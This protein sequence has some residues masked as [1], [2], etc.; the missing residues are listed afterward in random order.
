MPQPLPKYGTKIQP[1][2]AVPESQRRTLSVTSTE[3]GPLAPGKSLTDG[4]ARLPIEEW[5]GN[6]GVVGIGRFE[7]VTVASSHERLSSCISARLPSFCVRQCSMT[8]STK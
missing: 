5:V 6:G 8:R 1:L 2:F 7:Y 3:C 4:P